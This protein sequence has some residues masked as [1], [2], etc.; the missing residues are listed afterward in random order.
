MGKFGRQFRTQMQSGNSVG[1]EAVKLWVL[2]GGR[3]GK[4]GPGTHLFSLS[5]G[6]SGGTRGR[7]RILQGGGGRE[8]DGE[9]RVT[10]VPWLATLA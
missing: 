2:I 9:V 4:L 6:G 1:L 8:G 10:C 5:G 7:G 3:L